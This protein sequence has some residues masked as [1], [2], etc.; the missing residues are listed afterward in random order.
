MTGFAPTQHFEHALTAL[1]GWAH[2]HALDFTAPLSTNV[3]FTPPAGRVVHVNAV[4]QFE[5]GVSGHAMPLFLFQ[6][7]AAFDVANP[8]TSA[9]GHF[10]H[11]PVT[12]SG[13]M[14]GL[15]ATGGYELHSTEFDHDQ[16]YARNDLLTA[17]ADNADEDVGGVL[18]NKTAGD[19][20]IVAYGST[21]VC[22]VVS[23]GVFANEFSKSVLGFWPV[24]LP[25]STFVS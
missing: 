25:A 11:Q 15:V 17:P 23:R 19:D 24:Y 20:A 12:P 7:G 10:M 5:M 21:A 22:A 16:T 8:G 1:K 9:G 3:E 14:T 4:G 13:A 18:T 6:G 2:M